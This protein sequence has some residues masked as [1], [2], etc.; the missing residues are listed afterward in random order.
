L[1]KPVY[2]ISIHRDLDRFLTI[3]PPT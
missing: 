1:C 2:D 3:P